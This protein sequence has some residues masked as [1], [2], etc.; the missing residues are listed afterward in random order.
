MSKYL[1]NPGG[2]PRTCLRTIDHAPG[3]R[4]AAAL[5]SPSVSGKPSKVW[6][7]F[8]PAL[9]SFCR[10]TRQRA[11]GAD[12]SPEGTTDGSPGGASDSGHTRNPG[13]TEQV[14]SAPERAAETPCH[15]NIRADL[16][17]PFPGLSCLSEP[18]RVSRRN[19]LGRRGRGL[20][21][22]FS[23]CKWQPP[24]TVPSVGLARVL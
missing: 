21:A 9:A 7:T 12:A 5:Q 3:L 20:S 18:C 22:I 6:D 17:S 4:Q 10:E 19:K 8:S 13:E 16:S 11:P 2:K 1:N 14:T 24:L 23:E 15:H